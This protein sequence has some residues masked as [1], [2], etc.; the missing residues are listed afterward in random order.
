[1][2]GQ[3]I[4]GTG[5]AINLNG[6]DDFYLVVQP[7]NGAQIQQAATS[8]IGAAGSASW[9]LPN[10]AVTIGSGGDALTNYGPPTL[11][12]ADL[13][14]DLYNCLN[15]GANNL[16][17]VRVTD[18]TDVAAIFKI[19]DNTGFATD[20][21]TI[22][23]VFSTS[24]VVNITLTPVTGS[25]L[26]VAYQV[27]P[28]D[29]TLSG[30][31]VSVANFINSTSAVLGPNAFIQALAAP[32]AGAIV[33]K[34]LN[35]GTASNAIGVVS[36]VVGGTV[37]A[38]T[39]TA[40]LTGGAAAGA[41][42]SL[43]GR[44][45]GSLANNTQ[46]RIDNGSQFVTLSPTYKVTFFFPG[47]AGPEVYDNVVAYSTLGGGL[48][49]TSFQ[50]NLVNAIN[51]APQLSASRPASAYFLATAGASVLAPVTGIVMPIFSAGTDGSAFAAAGSQTYAQLGNDLSTPKTGM[52]AL[53]G[54]IGGGQ[55]FLCGNTDLANASAAQI[56]FAVR[57]NAHVFLAAPTGSSS[58]SSLASKAALGIASPNASL[59]Q[60]FH[61]FT[62]TINSVSGRRVAPLAINAAKMAIQ[63]P[64]T[65]PSNQRLGGVLTGTERF[66]TLPGVLPK[67]YSNTELGL[68][69]AA[70]I[71]C[72]TPTGPGVNA[73]CIRSNHNTMGA[74]DP[75]GQLA[76]S[77]MTKFLAA[78]LLSVGGP[79]VGLAQGSAPGDIVR[80][81]LKATLTTFVVGLINQGLLDPQSKDGVVVDKRNNPNAQ[82]AQGI[83]RFDLTLVYLAIID[84]VI[85]NFSGGQ[86][87][88]IRI[89][90]V[91]TTANS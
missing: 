35:Q 27:L 5:Q 1:M 44:Y 24:S 45:T 78:S 33:Y 88:Q 32:V 55:F 20:T 81:K 41:I 69:A 26:V 91:G 30:V 18:N 10:V 40:T 37:T 25:P 59:F 68:L 63:S 75:R 12:V 15:S 80:A 11:A 67:P 29:T 54:L 7:P 82:I 53:S 49:G 86:T 62:D 56:A 48:N 87:N 85:G 64:E 9:G 77:Q 58:A 52:Y 6:P 38:V 34:A 70:G 4:A 84:K 28:G 13:V 89:I 66:S 16:R 47:S 76:Y 17:A 74:A 65:S 50:T 61:E 19:N 14:T 79:F 60:D 8:I 22:A 57:E 3:L 39:T 21:T 36:S 73:F 31:A 71:N 51:G 90:P 43:A 72:N 83:L 2:P 46:I 23:G 42:V